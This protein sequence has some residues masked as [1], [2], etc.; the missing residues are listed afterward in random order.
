[1]GNEGALEISMF[2]SGSAPPEQA[3]VQ[4]AGSAFRMRIQLVNEEFRRGGP[5]QQVLLRY[6][7]V[8]ITQISQT[9]V[10]NRFHPLQKRLCR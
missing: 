2:I 9:I 10:C 5:F 3:L 1:V 6:T 8:L 7:Q 4:V